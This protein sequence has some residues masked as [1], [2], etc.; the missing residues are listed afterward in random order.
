[1][2]FFYKH[3]F[4]FIIVSFFAI[5]GITLALYYGVVQVQAEKIRQQEYQQRALKIQDEVADIIVLKQKATLAIAIAL[6]SQENL[7]KHVQY[8]TIPKHYFNAV[9]KKFR[10]KTLYEN[11]WI[12]IIDK[13]GKSLYRSWTKENGDNLVKVR[14]DIKT[15]QKTKQTASYLS[16]GYYDLSI[17]AMV[18]ILYKGEYL[19]IFELISHFNSIVKNFQEDGLESVVVATKEASKHIKHPFSKLFIGEYYVANLN[20]KQQFRDL[21]EKYG[22]ENIVK[23]PYSV[24]GNY[25]IVPCALKDS[26]KKIIGYYFIFQKMETLSNKELE[27]FTFKWIVLGLFFFSLFGAFVS[28][29]LYI[30]VRKQQKYYK[31]I[32]DTSKNII[33]INDK[34]KVLEANQ[35]FFK[36]F[37]HYKTLEEFRKENSCICSFFV[38]EEGYL[39]KGGTMYKWLDTVFQNPDVSH[40]VKM[41]IEGKIYYFLVSASLIDVEREHYSIVFSDITQE[42]IFKNKLQQSVITDPLTGIYNRRYYHEKIQKE[43]YKAKRYGLALSVIMTDIDFFKKINDTHG[44]DVGDEVLK[45]YTK[46]I[47]ES[48][49]ESDTFCRI[50]GEEFIIILP[51]TNKEQAVKIADKLRKTIEQS[52]KIIP[53]T[54]SFGVTQYISGESE[55]YLFKRVDN[56]LYRAKENGRNRVEVE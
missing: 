16:A 43:M 20:A 7:Q 5:V 35:T 47:Q 41:N 33:I 54:M 21:L 34:K 9:I 37:K 8:N 3:K 11:I 53:I 6:A 1:M 56:A 23:K 19:G 46:I 38:E 25:L 24:A 52:K 18:P 51:H 48:L 4:F 31:N 2:N 32:I 50:G 39:S 27:H 42:E 40:K 15:V 45:H 28:I 29:I 22:I 12:Q 26:K 30:F 13:H 10:Q 14:S 44:H 17:K 49:R 36:Y 55:D